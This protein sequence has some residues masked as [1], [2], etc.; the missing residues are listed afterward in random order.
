[1]SLC[2]PDPQAFRPPEEAANVLHVGLSTNF[3]AASSA[4]ES[5][6][7]CF[8]SWKPTSMR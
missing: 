1:M 2:S 8:E 5:T 7:C 4:D 6:I 3:K